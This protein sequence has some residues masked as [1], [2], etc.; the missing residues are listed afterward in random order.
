LPLPFDVKIGKCRYDMPALPDSA[1]TS[2]NS[3]PNMTCPYESIKICVAAL[4]KSVLR[5]KL[6]DIYYG[7]DYAYFITI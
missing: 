1:T 2:D 7:K 5:R 6:F 3:L 4:H